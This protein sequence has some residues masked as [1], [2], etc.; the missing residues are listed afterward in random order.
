MSLL[1]EDDP[2]EADGQVGPSRVALVERIARS[3]TVVRSRTPSAV[4]ALVGPWGSGKT[5]V[6]EAVG[7]NFTAN[8]S[9]AVA[10]YNPWSY[11]SLDTAVPGFFSEIDGALPAELR[12]SG[13]RA[14]LGKWV[15]RL[16]PLGAFGSMLG[17]DMAQAAQAAADL[18][19][20]NQSPEKL[21][22]E[23]ETVLR[24]LKTPILV[25]IDDLDRL[26][27]DELLMTFRLVRMLGRLP[28]IYYLLCYD[29]ATLTDVLLQTGLV[30]N[31]LGRAHEYLEKMVQLRIDIPRM[32]PEEKS[33]LS[34][35][36]LEEVL[37]GHSVVLSKADLAR[38]RDLRKVC[39]DTYLAQPRAAKR[40]FTQV[41]AAWPTLAGE[42]D[43]VDFVA[44]TF[45]RTFEPA[46]HGFLE[47]VSAQLLVPVQDSLDIVKGNHVSMNWDAWI[48]EIRER[49]ARHPEKVASLLAELFVTVHSA[50]RGADPVPG[51]SE[52]LAEKQRVGHPDFFYRYTQIDIPKN[53]LPDKTL[54]ECIRELENNSPSEATAMTERVLADNPRLVVDKLV[55]LGNERDLPVSPLLVMISRSYRILGSPQSD[56]GSAS[57]PSLRLAVHL[58][59]NLDRPSV[60]ATIR[61]NCGEL[62][63]LLLM[64]DAIHSISM[65]PNGRDK[66]PWLSTA[67][68]SIALEIQLQLRLQFAKQ[69]SPE[70]E[71]L[72]LNIF[73]LRDFTSRESVQ[74]LLWEGLKGNS[75]WRVEDVLAMLLLPKHTRSEG[76]EWEVSSAYLSAE[77]VDDLL[78]IERIAGEID[79]DSTTKVQSGN[80]VE[81]FAEFPYFH[82]R[83]AAAMFAFNK[84]LDVYWD[85]DTQHETLAEPG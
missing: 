31:D 25:L 81:R 7:A 1:Y 21:R 24:S 79:Q 72:L 52:R 32:L 61:E 51:D 33:S 12:K 80:W 43:F 34:D 46:I 66:V 84:M 16:A 50:R 26:G 63:G 22:S 29:E 4:I 56:A 20:G 23:A 60:A 30:S 37:T 17:A 49:G 53:D 54:S 36:L 59:Q 70:S 28:N 85:A 2:I 82:E 78:G 15:S 83:K 9:F 40:L 38:L 11:S 74:D 18:L 58:L 10:R 71:L 39:I 62:R 55:R 19:N 14:A 65:S 77:V 6:M 8:D 73:A 5:S 75:N 69:A 35:A 76:K 44:M 48:H 57:N 64:S 67:A 3:L 45:L 68:E 47:E 42:I 13:A 27:P 41:D